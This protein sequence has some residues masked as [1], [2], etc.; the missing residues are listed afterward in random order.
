MSELDWKRAYP[1]GEWNG[2]YRAID[3]VR[4]LLR[5][6]RR[7]AVS[8]V[9]DVITDLPMQVGEEKSLR[10]RILGSTAGRVRFTE[11][12]QAILEGVLVILE[13][14]KLRECYERGVE[15]CGSL[16]VE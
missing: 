9:G 2:G 13:S 15:Q 8:I 1:S 3:A 12:L 6:Y 10:E 5:M 7:M 16:A 11:K 4:S 14:E